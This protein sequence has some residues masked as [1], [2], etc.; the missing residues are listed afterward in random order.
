MRTYPLG[1]EIKTPDKVYTVGLTTPPLEALN[2][3]RE[4]DIHH[5]IVVD[6]GQV[7][8]VISD[9]NIFETAEFGGNAVT[10]P[11]G[12]QVQDAMRSVPPVNEK[13]D[14]AEAISLI[15]D[16]KI[17]ALPLSQEGKITGIVTET[18]LLRMMERLL[19]DA[20]ELDAADKSQLYM[21]NPLVQR[22]MKLL[23]E[24]G[25]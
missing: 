14:I 5:L 4:R 24:A 9:R 13:T 12:A 18:D 17:S 16:H 7:V 22:L 19:T 20:E 6:Q 8:G 1:T 2:L 25:I 3:M 11:E 15:R 21:S 10:F 23:S